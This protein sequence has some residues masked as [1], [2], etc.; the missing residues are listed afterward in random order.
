MK[1]H[2]TLPPPSF[3][4]SGVEVSPQLEAAVRHALEKEIAAR[5]PS[6]EA[7]IKELKQTGAEGGGTIGPGRQTAP[8]PDQTLYSPAASTGETSQNFG[9]SF[10]CIA[11]IVP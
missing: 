2:L 1:K 8:G 9:A 10:D 4:S 7:F 6:V 11:G 3:K 5:T